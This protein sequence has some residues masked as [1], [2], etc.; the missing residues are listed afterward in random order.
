ML[1]RAGAVL[2]LLLALVVC[3]PAEAASPVQCPASWVWNAGYRACVLTAGGGGENPGHPGGGGGGGGGGEPVCVY[4]GRLIPCETGDGYW[5]GPPNECYIKI[6]DPQPPKSDDV[7]EGHTDGA[8]YD[9]SKRLLAGTND[10]DYQ[11]WWGSPPP[12]GGTDPTVLIAQAITRMGLRGI[13]M[14]STPPMI[15]GRI[16]LIGLPTWLWA[17]DPTPQTW[18]PTSASA[19][20]GGVTITARAAAKRVLWEMGTGESVECAGPGTP[21]TPPD[22]KTDSPT[23]GYRYTDDGYYAVQ[24]VTFWDL[25]WSGMGLSGTIPLALFSRGQIVMGELQ[26][27]RTG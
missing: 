17:V 27:I 13:T 25:T 1:R 18:G 8:I 15:T 14:G 4:S 26:V 12:A 7:W 23:C 9:C 16:G 11:K 20:A 3:R 5:I 2:G 19:S 10:L 24:A 22:G 21:W 6:A